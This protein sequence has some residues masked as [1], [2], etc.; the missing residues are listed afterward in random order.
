MLAWLVPSIAALFGIGW[1]MF[2][3]FHPR[4]KCDISVKVQDCKI[5][6]KIVW[7]FAGSDIDGNFVSHEV[8]DDFVGKVIEVASTGNTAV[9]G[10]LVHVRLKYPIRHW[11]IHT[12]EQ[13]AEPYGLPDDFNVK[14]HSLN[15]K[16]VV[17][18]LVYCNK[19][20]VIEG[21]ELL[22]DC[23]VSHNDGCAK[24]L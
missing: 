1:A 5:N 15:P 2:E 3:H 17:R 9:K 16:D 14:I 6:D 4:L 21:E 11:C 23:R 24:M 12:D 20:S 7:G 8:R 22:E 13:Y 19:A 18:V 10:L